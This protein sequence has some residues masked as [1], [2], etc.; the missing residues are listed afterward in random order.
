MQWRTDLR[1]LKII[2]NSD[3]KEQWIEYPKKGNSI[4]FT[5]RV[6]E[7]P[8]AYEIGMTDNKIFNGYWRGYF[9][10]YGDDTRVTFTEEATIVNPFYRALP[11]LFF[12]LG[13]TIDRY[14]ILLSNALRNHPIDR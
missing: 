10:A 2:R 1:D 9:E 7:P 5:V 14:L 12:D 13:K 3:N 11:F 6:K 4:T 8:S